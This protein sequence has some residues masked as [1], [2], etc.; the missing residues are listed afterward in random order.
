MNRGVSN[1]SDGSSA[2]ADE[3]VARAVVAATDNDELERTKKNAEA[4]T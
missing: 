1:T 2:A 3:S 4:P